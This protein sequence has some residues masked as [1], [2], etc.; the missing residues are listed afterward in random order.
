MTEIVF[1]CIDSDINKFLFSFF[2]QLVFKN[3]K[4][5]FLYSNSADKLKKLDQILWD[6]CRDTDFLPHSIYNSKNESQKYERLLLSD[7]FLNF[8]SA[9]YLLI[10]SFLDN[11]DFINNFEKVFYVYTNLNKG[12]LE[13]AKTSF[14]SYKNLNYKLTLNTKINNKWESCNDFII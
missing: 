14:D 13:N 4:K 5:V 6:L 7:K 3:N 2:N 9:D 11:L 10:S 1:Y 12:S 8:N